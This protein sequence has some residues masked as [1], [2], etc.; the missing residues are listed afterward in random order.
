MF[1]SNRKVIFTM[2]LVR[3]WVIA[4]YSIAI[5]FEDISATWFIPRFLHCVSLNAGQVSWRHQPVPL[6]GCQ[7]LGLN[8]L[9]SFRAPH[10]R[11][12]DVVLRELPHTH[13]SEQ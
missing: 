13:P 5:G 9:R 8:C 1:Y 11:W 3:G 12:V 7:V 10:K 2:G 6:K 4:V